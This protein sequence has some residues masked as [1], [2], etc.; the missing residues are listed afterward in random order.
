MA[1]IRAAH[2][3]ETEARLMEDPIVIAMAKG[4]ADVPRKEIAHEDGGARFE[5]MQAANAQYRERGGQDGGHIGAI[6]N[7]LIKLL[8]SGIAPPT[9]VVSFHASRRSANAWRDEDVAMSSVSIHAGDDE[10]AARAALTNYMVNIE[11]KSLAEYHGK[12][13]GQWATDRMAAIFEALQQTM[14]AKF[15]GGQSREAL[16]FE[17]DGII[18]SLVRSERAA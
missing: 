10:D 7:A 5:F 3:G 12:P 16:S 15:E 8:D 14:V 17:A 18:F 13:G 4:L 9:K 6:A 1:V 11:A 2:Y